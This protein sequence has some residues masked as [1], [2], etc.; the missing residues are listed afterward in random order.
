MRRTHGFLAA[1]LA[2]VALAPICATARQHSHPPRLAKKTA[3]VNAQQAESLEVR[4]GLRTANGVT[5]TTP[6]GGLMARQTVAKSA[7]T[8]TR[9]FIAKQSATSS[10]LTL[11]SYLPGVVTA[12]SD[13]LGQ[14]S[15]SMSMRG[16]QQSEIGFTYEDFPFADSIN[17]TPYTQ[18]IVDTD[19]IASITVNQ[20]APDI[21]SPVYNDVG[22]LIKISLRHA[23]QEFGGTA[24]FSFGSKAL[25]RE[26]IR[27]DSGEIGHSGIKAFASFSSTTNDQW[28]GSGQ[29]RK[30]HVDAEIRKDWTQNTSLGLIFSYDNWEQSN[31]RNMTLTSWKDYGISHNYNK[32][33]YPGN[34]NWVGLNRYERRSTVILL[35][36]R[37]KLFDGLDFKLTPSFAQYHEYYLG[38]TTLSNTNSYMGTQPAG[39]LNLPGI[40][41]ATNGGTAAAESINPVPQDAFFINSGL[42]WKKGN[43]ILRFGQTYQYIHLFEQI[44]YTGVALDGS[45]SNVEGKY[46]ITLSD[47]Q[48]YMTLNQNFTHQMNSF[49]LDD[50][51]KLLGGR[52]A[53][54]AGLK[55]IMIDRT[56]VNDTPGAIRYAGGSYSQP[57]PQFS[58]SYQIS[59]N[60]QIFIDATTAYRA[61]ESVEAYGQ[62]WSPHSN[63]PASNFVKMDGEYAIGEEI[64]FRH[65]GLVNVSLSLFNYNITNNQVQTYVL[66]GNEA[67]PEPLQ[68]GGKTLRGVD[69]ELGMRPW[70]HFSPYVSAQYLH[71]TMDNNYSAENAAGQTVVLPTAGKTAVQSPHFVAAVG[72]S[73]DNGTYFG[74]FYFNY[75]SSQYSTFM[76]DEKIPGYEQANVTLGYRMHPIG[77]LKYPQLQI[78][79]TNIGNN[80]YLSGPSSVTANAHTYDGVTG[81][82]PLYT[83]NGGIAVVASLSTGF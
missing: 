79:V 6:G 10:P 12:G 29:F 57:L 81:H 77:F 33:Y 47:G 21:S 37:A 35:P 17:Y 64:G 32:S 55:Y 73:Y 53:L 45:V 42:I 30:Y 14:S 46:P 50:T 80:N 75:V 16:L 19:N 15:T 67:I 54:N 71:A 70:H 1:L 20:G 36:F 72:I 22:G 41:S 13:P 38:G 48:R 8:L 40:Y 11:I 3:A 43:N 51:L 9:D 26:F 83:V 82:A 52:L 31:Y 18:T 24:N 27:I 4:G 56:M 49:Y 61:P 60:D 39:N 25:Q 62:L 65:Y 69:V 2:S 76:N 74:N 7:S 34:T 78:N 68:N 23:R 44:F 63:Q 59:K 5:N 28:R 58:A 66:L